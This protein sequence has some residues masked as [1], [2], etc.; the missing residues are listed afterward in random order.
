[1]GASLVGIALPVL[2]PA[3]ESYQAVVAKLED[4]ARDLKKTMLLVGTRS[5]EE[6]VKA[7]I[8]GR[9]PL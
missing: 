7:K 5:I 9:D 1:M 6:L 4:L 2:K 8:I 3:T